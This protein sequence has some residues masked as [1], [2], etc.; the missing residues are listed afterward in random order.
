MTAMPTPTMN[1]HLK[2]WRGLNG[3]SLGYSDGQFPETAVLSARRLTKRGVS[4]AY[5]LAFIRWLAWES[6]VKSWRTQ[7]GTYLG[8]PVPVLCLF[9]RR[10][11]SKI[12]TLPIKSSHTLEPPYKLQ[13]ADTS[14]G[15]KRSVRHSTLKHGFS[16]TFTKP[17]SG[18]QVLAAAIAIER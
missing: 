11:L 10:M 13:Y 1:V 12:T 14:A 6:G 9:P 3:S 17:R 2:A 7:C 4:S 16:D 15:L 5:G 8:A 18:M